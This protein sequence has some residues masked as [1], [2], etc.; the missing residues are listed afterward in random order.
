MDD[1]TLVDVDELFRLRRDAA[2]WRSL[3]RSPHAHSILREWWEWRQHKNMAQSA[4]AISFTGDWQQQAQHPT[5]AELARRRT[6]YE[7]EPLTPE[8]IRTRAALNWQAHDT[9]TGAAA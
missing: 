3:M 7:H 8:Q 6:T 2:A 4:S 9:P 1:T 5:F